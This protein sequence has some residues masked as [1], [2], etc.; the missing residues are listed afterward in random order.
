MTTPPTPQPLPP[1]AL[2]GEEAKILMWLCRFCTSDDGWLCYASQ[3][4]ERRAKHLCEIGYAR[5]RR[6][7]GPG[8][9]DTCYQPTDAGRAALAEM[10]DEG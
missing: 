7:Y 6:Y 10:E 3:A 9:T 4:D 8:E 2:D 1:S 5:S